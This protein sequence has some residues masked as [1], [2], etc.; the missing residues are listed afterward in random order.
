MATETP[1]PGHPSTPQE[2]VAP[3]SP[4]QVKGKLRSRR[5]FSAERVK[6]L[7]TLTEELAQELSQPIKFGRWHTTDVVNFNTHYYQVTVFPHALAI[8]G[9]LTEQKVG[10]HGGIT[11]TQ[12]V[13]TH[14][15]R[16][17]YMPHIFEVRSIPIMLLMSS[18]YY[19]KK[20]LTSL[21]VGRAYEPG[22]FKD[23]Q[24][25]IASYNIRLVAA[26][27]IDN[28]RELASAYEI[29]NQRQMSDQERGERIANRLLQLKEKENRAFGGMSGV[30]IRARLT[31]IY[32]QRKKTIG[33][34]AFFIFLGIVITWFLFMMAMGAAP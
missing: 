14:K 24:K 1:Q 33:V 10:L 18:R 29:M 27:Y 11:T 21:A 13:D 17:G 7:L 22:D 31:T 5:P 28:L 2:G 6:E 4:N 12:L 30:P 32:R 9:G 23:I 20:G 16:I 15:V 3:V 26:Q 19:W 34:M 25:V 8:L